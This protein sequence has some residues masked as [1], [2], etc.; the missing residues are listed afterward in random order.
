MRDPGPSENLASVTT[1]ETRR[2]LD[3]LGELVRQHPELIRHCMRCGRPASFPPPRQLKLRVVGKRVYE[4]LQ[5]PEGA[6]IAE[7]RI[8]AWPDPEERRHRKDGTIFVMLARLDYRLWAHG[9]A[10]SRIGIGNK[11]RIYRV[12]GI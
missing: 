6:T 8:A 5:K 12:V 7:L 10:I 1:A 9:L 2:A 3:A 4:A 11:E